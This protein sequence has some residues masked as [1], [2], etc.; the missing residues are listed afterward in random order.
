VLRNFFYTGNYLCATSCLIRKDA[1]L[2][3]G[4][5]NPFLLQLQDFELWIKM[6][7]NGH[8]IEILEEKLT[9]YRISDSNLSSIATQNSNFFSR[10]LFETEKVLEVFL[11]IKDTN[12]M[13]NIFPE[14]KKTFTEM[15]PEYKDLY[16]AKLALLK[17]VE[18]NIVSLAYRNFAMNA[19][20]KNVYDKSNHKQILEELN[21]STREFFELS[22]SNYLVSC[23]LNDT[24]VEKNVEKKSIFRKMQN[25]IS[26][27][28]NKIKKTCS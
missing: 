12:L 16:I 3:C 25:S 22:A 1:L 21:F 20:Y 27:R 26:K 15:K 10:I 2:S 19:I 9:Y 11:T 8:K 24:Y 6:L 23:N 4:Y 18:N 28:I 17:S 5:F 14:L 7:I 13:I